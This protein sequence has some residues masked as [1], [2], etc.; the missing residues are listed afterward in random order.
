MTGGPFDRIVFGTARL[1][2]GAYARPSRR[3]IES[4][5]KHGIT[6]FD[7]APSYGMG[8]A[9]GLLGEVTASAPGV[10][11]ATKLGSLRPSYPALRGWAKLGYRLSGLHRADDG[12]IGPTRRYSGPLPGMDHSTD[13]C[14]R[15]FE[16]SLKLLRRERIELLFLHEAEPGDVPPETVSLIKH[17]HS[18][19]LID[20]A[21]AAH[22]GPAGALPAGWVAQ[23]APDPA[24]FSRA[25][26]NAAPQRFHS[27]RTV[28]QFAAQ[29]DP[30]LAQR[31]AS[32]VNQI[33]DGDPNGLAPLALLAALKPNAQLIYATT[34][35][36]RLEAFIRT[37]RS[38]DLAA[39]A[40]AQQ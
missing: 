3:L 9:E 6:Q 33:G 26:F 38:L 37:W 40:E 15:S 17:W 21:G 36:D 7:T 19:G 18:Q 1:A 27:I 5:L 35:Q 24:A 39:I 11:I 10:E 16:R 31:L 32:A 14:R 8:A 30:G 13:A 2:G 20:A 25:N 4:C 22:Q 34:A 12:A 29:A 28:A 23:I